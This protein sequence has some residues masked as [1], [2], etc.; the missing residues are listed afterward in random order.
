MCVCATFCPCVQYGRNVRILGDGD[1][2]EN[3][4]IFAC[5]FPFNCFCAGPKR[6]DMRNKYGLQEVCINDFFTT[7]CCKCCSLIQIAAEIDTRGVPQS[8]AGPA[9]VTMA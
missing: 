2:L 3:C 5:C 8:Q 1:F 4:C 9:G 7:C 6:T